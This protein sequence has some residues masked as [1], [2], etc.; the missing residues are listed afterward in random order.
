[1]NLPV[2][3]N[4]VVFALTIAFLARRRQNGG[5]V[6]SNVLLAVLLGVAL[7]ALAQA[8][9]GLGQPGHR[10][11]PAVGGHCRHRLRPAAADG[12]RAAGAG[13]HPGRGHQAQ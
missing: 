3:A 6:S 12:H 2:F 4:V 13:L 5:S 11:H 8:V 1:M 7:G 10:R 9:Y